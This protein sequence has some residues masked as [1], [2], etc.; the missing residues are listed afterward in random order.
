MRFVRFDVNYS[1]T[2]GRREEFVMM[3]CTAT[4]HPFV[5]DF[6]ALYHRNKNWAFA[7]REFLEQ[8]ETFDRVGVCGRAPSCPGCVMFPLEDRQTSSNGRT[9]R[10][11][12]LRLDFNEILIKNI[13][14]RSGYV[15]LLF[16]IT[17]ELFHCNSLTIY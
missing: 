16:L 7:S 10:A 9:L 4:Q 17:F 3:T 13:N 5:P 2:S 14:V 8:Q 12:F 1:R 15:R 6:R 11:S